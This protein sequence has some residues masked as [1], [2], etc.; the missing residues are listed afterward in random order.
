MKKPGQ[1]AILKSDD[2]ENFGSSHILV[3]ACWLFPMDGSQHFG[4]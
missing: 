3:L 4:S 2:I 1:I